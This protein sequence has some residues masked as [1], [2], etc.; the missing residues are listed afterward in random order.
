MATIEGMLFPASWLG[1]P[2]ETAAEPDDSEFCE[3]EERAPAARSCPLHG[4]PEFF[5]GTDVRP[6]EIHGTSKEATR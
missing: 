2:Y 5:D 4:D 3:C 6:T 1:D